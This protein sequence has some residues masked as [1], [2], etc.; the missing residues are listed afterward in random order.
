MDDDETASQM[1][2]DINAKRTAALAQLYFDGRLKEKPN[3]PYEEY[4]NARIYRFG[5]GASPSYVFLVEDGKVTYFVRYQRVRHNGLKLGRQVL[6][7]RIKMTAATA[8]FA[9]DIFFDELLPKYHALIADKEQTEFG[10][11]FWMNA[12]RRAFA[13]GLPVYFLDRRS[14][15]NQLIRLES[16]TDLLKYED[17]I[18]GTDPRHQLTFA[19]IS[20]RPLALK[21]KS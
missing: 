10:K 11:N 15:P 19:V 4:G 1:I 9:Q 5:D 12:C 18:W 6:V 7:L 20:N 2:P 17:A 3:H 8:G 14:S 16:R 21:R 13:Q